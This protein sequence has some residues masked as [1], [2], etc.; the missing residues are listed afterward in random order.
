MYGFMNVKFIFVATTQGNANEGNEDTELCG[1]YV[2]YHL[3]YET[4]P[5]EA[6]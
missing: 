4:Q 2:C 3:F 1:C 5:R 6:E